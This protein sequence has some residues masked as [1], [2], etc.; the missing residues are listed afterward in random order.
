MEYIGKVSRYFAALDKS[1]CGLEA[2]EIAQA[3]ALA[4]GFDAFGIGAEDAAGNFGLRFDG[5]QAG[6]Y[7][8][9]IRAHGAANPIRERAFRHRRPW[10]WTAAEMRTGDFD[11]AAYGLRWGVACGEALSDGAR[12]IINYGSSTTMPPDNRN[13]MDAIKAIMLRLNLEIVTALERV[14]WFDVPGLTER[15][16]QVLELLCAGMDR[17]TIA[18][19]LDIAY[20]TVTNRIN[21]MCK[22]TGAKNEKELIARFAAKMNSKKMGAKK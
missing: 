17:K 3:A 10:H 18:P 8:A 2:I 19:R 12:I 6:C 14:G 5:F 1:D 16:W 13:Q 4:I 9:Y 21:D 11:P 7:A 20:N 22:I 15:H